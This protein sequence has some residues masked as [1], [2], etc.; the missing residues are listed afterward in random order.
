MNRDEYL[1]LY[2]TAFLIAINITYVAVAKI[3]FRT[4]KANTSKNFKPVQRLYKIYDKSYI[5]NYPSKAGQNF[6]KLHNK[7][8]IAFNIIIIISFLSFVAI[9]MFFL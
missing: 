9:A 1:I 5:S 8:T 7:V 4:S 6:F 2:F 3:L